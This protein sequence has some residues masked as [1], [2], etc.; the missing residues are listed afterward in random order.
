MTDTPAASGGL[1]VDRHIARAIRRRRRLL[2]ITQAE[3]ARRIGVRFQQVSKYES[4]AN[5]LTAAR[6]FELARALRVSVAD[7]FPPLED[8]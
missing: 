3:L 8:A 5:R 7:L 2:D 4:G 6:A 1:D